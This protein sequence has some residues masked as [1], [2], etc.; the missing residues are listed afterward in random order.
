MT[1][2]QLSDERYN[3]V[4]VEAGNLVLF[5]S[6]ERPDNM[7]FFTDKNEEAIYNRATHKWS[8][9]LFSSKEDGL[10]A[11]PAGNKIKLPVWR[12]KKQ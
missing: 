4:I 9:A 11:A 1:I 10:T 12:I 6:G 5:A 8:T 7:G 3:L 2:G